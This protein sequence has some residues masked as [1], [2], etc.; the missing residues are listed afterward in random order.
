M[1][2][3]NP[4]FLQKAE[5]IRGRRRLVTL[6]LLT[7]LSLLFLIVAFVL[8]VS[9][10]QK[11]Y[12]QLYPD[13]VGHATG[14]S[15]TITYE[16]SSQSETETTPSSSETSATEPVL[17]P[18]IVTSETTEATSA[19]TTSLNPDTLA[20]DD[21]HFSSPRS[22]IASHQR[23]AVL[24]DNMKNQIERYVRLLPSMRICF[25]YISLKTGESIGVNELDP[26]VPASTF[27]LPINIV[28][29]QKAKAGQV[30]PSVVI[31]YTGH[32]SVNGSYIYENYPAGKQIYYS[33]LSHLSLAYSDRVALEM[34]I[35]QM[36]GMD[37]ILPSINEISSFQPYDST[38]FYTDYSGTDYRG[39]GRSTCFDMANYAQYL[40]RSY[41]SD[42]SCYQSI[43]NS[44]SA[45][46]VGSPIRSAFGVDTPILHIYGRNSDLHAYTELAI[47]DTYEPIV[48][49]IYIE[50]DNNTEVLTAFSTIGGYVNEFITGCYN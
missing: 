45:S 35:D 40:Y 38:V 41:I 30:N 1:K 37:A 6:I 5:S 16:S 33:Y 10:R 29:C 7:V 14:T 47:I 15:T 22:Q 8:F 2:A 4:I 13:M 25:Q 36:G 21:F 26:I 17:A 11:E 50:G 18:S 46:Q 23:R 27:A 39:P 32:S 12:A 3:P 19:E 42:P 20:M 49:C 24:L 9:A 48:V 43:I 34:L 28:S 44:M 31:T